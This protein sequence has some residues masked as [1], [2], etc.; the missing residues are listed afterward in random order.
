MIGVVGSCC[1]DELLYLDYLPQ[2]GQDAHILKREMK[3][4][5]CAYYVAKAIEDCT[6]ISS[7]G[8]GVYADFI[9]DEIENENFAC[10]FIPRK[11]ENGVCMCMIEPTGQRTFMSLQGAEYDL[12][13]ELLDECDEYD[14]L[15]LSGIDLESNEEVIEYLQ[16]H[17]KHIFFSPGPRFEKIKNLDSILDLHPI[18]HMNMDE[19]NCMTQ[20]SIED[21]M[22]E[23]FQRTNQIVFVTDG[24][25]GS[26]AYD[27]QLHFVPS[28][29]ICPKNSVGAGDSHT[30][31][32]LKGVHDGKKMD[33]ILKE[34][35][36][37][38]AKILENK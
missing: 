18:L 9:L 25:K 8:K 35:N 31:I 33:L 5:G 32:C 17:P 4:G 22:K 2:S 13:Q 36:E 19:L 28:I 3:L 37:Y 30:G 27:G 7:I 29:P 20:A 6:L 34:A 23:L 38:A 14:W 12:C 10:T 26:Y 15:Y 1:V 21:G 11:E 24:E 16:K